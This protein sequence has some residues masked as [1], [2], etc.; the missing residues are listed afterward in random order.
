M[1]FKKNANATISS[2]SSSSVNFFFTI[3]SVLFSVVQLNNSFYFFL[4]WQFVLCFIFVLFFFI[5]CYNLAI[6]DSG[7]QVQSDRID[8]NV[9]TI[10]VS[11]FAFD[12][13]SD[14]QSNSNY[15]VFI[16]FLFIIQWFLFVQRNFRHCI[17]LQ[18]ISIFC[19]EVYAN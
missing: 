14:D 1:H 10:L 7:C 8:W 15:N 6:I 16:V 19:I 12:E 4:Y 17:K 13:D 11:L 3:R 2:A 5:T 18:N 9:F